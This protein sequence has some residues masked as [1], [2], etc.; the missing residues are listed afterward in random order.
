MNTLC[1]IICV[2]S[3]AFVSSIVSADEQ[4]DR[5]RE[6]LRE[7]PGSESYNDDQ[8]ALEERE[9]DREEKEQKEGG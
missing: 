4:G 1:K 7:N 3:L 9:R 2:M 6:I 8:S 5:E